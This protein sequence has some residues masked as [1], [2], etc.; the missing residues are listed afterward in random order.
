[1]LCSSSDHSKPIPVEKHKYF[2]VFAIPPLSLIKRSQ[3]SSPHNPSG[4][5]GGSSSPVFLPLV[6]LSTGFQLAR[7]VAMK[8]P[9][10]AV[11][12]L[13][14]SQRSNERE[15][16]LQM[17]DTKWGL[18]IDQGEDLSWLNHMALVSLFD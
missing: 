7:V 3:S 18:K 11:Y 16:P 9:E 5:P 1:M 13:T 6:I 8:E 17:A 10:P 2:H 4:M 14:R 15:N 12:M